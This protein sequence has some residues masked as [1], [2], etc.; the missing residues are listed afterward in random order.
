MNIVFI[1]YFADQFFVYCA[2]YTKHPTH[3]A[4][5]LGSIDSYSVLEKIN[6][7]DKDRGE[8]ADCVYDRQR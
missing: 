4:I 6:N 5:E 8:E 7:E 1:D 3:K 2:D